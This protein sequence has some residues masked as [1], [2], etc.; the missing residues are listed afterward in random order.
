MPHPGPPAPRS[1]SASV[2]VLG[3]IAAAALF[4]LVVVAQ[5]YWIDDSFISF[6]Y[7]RQLVEGNGLVY[8]AGDPVEGYSNFLWMLVSALGMSLGA[9][10][11]AFTQGAALL[12]Q[13]ATLWALYEIGRTAGHAGWRPL[14]APLFLAGSIAFLAYPMTGMET[15]F[16]TLLVTLAFLGL[17]RGWH[18]TRGGALLLGLLLLALPLTRFDGFVPVIL[19]VSYPLLFERRE[20]AWRALA[21]PLGVF[22]AGLVAYNAW[23]IAYYPTALPNTVLAKVAFS[24]GRVLEGLDHLAAF[25][26]ERATIPILLGL[27]PFALRHASATARHLAWVVFGQAGY[28]AVV[29]GDWM[30]HFRF[31]LPVLPLLFALMQEGWVLL[32]DALEER[33]PSPRF[34][35]AAAVLLLF[36]FHL[37]PMRKALA[38][39]EVAGKHFDPHDARRIGE[40][41]DANLP[42]DK[43]VAVEWGGILPFYTH[44]RV[45]DTW[46]L[47][48]REAVQRPDLIKQ[49]WGTRM[50]A[51]YLAQRKPDLIAGNARLLPTQEAAHKSYQPGGPNRYSYYP[52]MANPK[53][54]YRWQIFKLA[55]DAW[56]P[57][58][59]RRQ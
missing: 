9:E 43:L 59:V 20:G 52:T 38:F 50:N 35:A 48:D 30:P 1:R 32:V 28:V 44:H 34:S 33:V 45:L 12:A 56:W 21:V 5:N 18:R 25:A 37:A 39:E 19:L 53:H 11:L 23:R 51:A 57:A 26:R 31:L 14:F 22:L 47:T 55:D 41:L 10:P 3:L 27:L 49:V 36:A 16:F 42:P 2:A 17:R 40:F 8:N 7:A 6:R 46:S 58:L 15:T 4:S 24:P 54:G 13:A 29:G